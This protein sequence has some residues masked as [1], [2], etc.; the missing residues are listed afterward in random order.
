MTV[1]DQINR[2]PGCS[3]HCRLDHVRCKYGQKYVEKIQNAQARKAA[4]GEKTDA[5]KH[6]YKWEKYVLQGGLAWKLLWAARCS[7]RALR[8]SKMTEQTLLSVLD[9]T[10][11]AQLGAL[12]D[13][14]S[15]RFE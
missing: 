7:K 15:K 8:R 11:Q 12:L 2:C 9:E 6:A 10:E 3:R 1:K 13:K 4:G 14:L 5:K